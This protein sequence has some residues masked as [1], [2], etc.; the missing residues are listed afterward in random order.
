MV[1]L[2]AFLKECRRFDIIKIEV[3]TMDFPKTGSPYDC[4]LQQTLGM[5]DR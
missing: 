4:L 1:R 5:N 3:K 2:Q